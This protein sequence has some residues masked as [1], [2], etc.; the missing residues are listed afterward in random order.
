MDREN[1][2]ILLQNLKC[3]GDTERSELQKGKS[4]EAFVSVAALRSAE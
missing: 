2:F 1:V 3:V 4:D